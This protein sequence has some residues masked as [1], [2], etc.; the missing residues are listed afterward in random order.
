MHFK[1]KGYTIA[2][3]SL[4]VVYLGIDLFK[5]DRTDYKKGHTDFKKDHVE[6]HLFNKSDLYCVQGMN[7]G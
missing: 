4:G 2:V 7:K 3:M 5:K 1:S 6:S